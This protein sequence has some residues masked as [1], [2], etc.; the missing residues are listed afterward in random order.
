MRVL[1]PGREERSMSSS[2]MPSNLH[3]LVLKLNSIFPLTE[4]EKQAVL[5]LPMHVREFAA[6]Q[7]IV[8]EGDRPSQCCLLLEGFVQ[9]YQIVGEGRRQIMSFH[10]Q[11]DMPDLLSLHTPVMDHSLGT[12]SR[13]KVGFIPHQ[14]IRHMIRD[15]PRIRDALWRDTLIDAAVFR[16]WMV[17]IGQRDARARISHLFCE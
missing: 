2:E 4:D 5:G 11:G 12:L 3:S 8:R 15:H 1:P 7:D 14:S 6:D 10:H 17:G 9:R 13:S 16:Q